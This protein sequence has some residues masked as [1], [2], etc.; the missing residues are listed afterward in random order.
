M[1][2]YKLVYILHLQLFLMVVATSHH[3]FSSLKQH[4]SILLQFWKPEVRNQFYWATVK[5]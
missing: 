4:K 5:A 2:T 3:Q 1:T